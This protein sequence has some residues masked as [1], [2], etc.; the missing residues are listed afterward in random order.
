[1]TKALFTNSNV[2]EVAK[3]LETWIKKFSIIL[4]GGTISIDGN[5][6]DH[7][8]W[9]AIMLRDNPKRST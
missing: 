1:M 7:A 9:R 4:F 6:L 8:P 2:D 3:T 5:A